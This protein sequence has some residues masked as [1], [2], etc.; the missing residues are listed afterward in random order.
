[1][2][3]LSAADVQ[4]TKSKLAYELWERRG[5]PFGSPEVDWMA[6]EAM[7]ASESEPERAIAAAAGD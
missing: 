5:C 2:D 3:E 1:M 4:E 6:A 7:L